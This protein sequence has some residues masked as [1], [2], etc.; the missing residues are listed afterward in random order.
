MGYQVRPF[1]QPILYP[2]VS[3]LADLIKERFTGKLDE[4]IVYTGGILNFFAE[5]IHVSSMGNATI[6]L[7]P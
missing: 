7:L 2:T 3:R 5:H 6:E 4:L 1:Y